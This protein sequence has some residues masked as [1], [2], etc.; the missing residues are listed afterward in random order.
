MDGI[1]R[2]SWFR[3]AGLMQSGI[4][5]TMLALGKAGKS[6]QGGIEMFMQTLPISSWFYIGIEAVNTISDVVEDP[7]VNIPYGQV[8]SMLT[9][10]VTAF[11]VLFEYLN[12]LCFFFLRSHC[13]P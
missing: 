2:H 6:F 5:L 3:S 1:V 7:R 4:Q 9:L 13:N 10:L 12:Q 11:A 8:L